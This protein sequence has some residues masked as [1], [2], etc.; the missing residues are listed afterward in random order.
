MRPLTTAFPALRHRNFRLF[1]IGQFISL[2]GTWM[3]TVAQ[4]W[5]VLQL[6][7]S[8]FAV[9]LVSMLGSLPVLLF[10]LY[11]GVLADRVNRRRSVILLQS[12]MLVEALTLALL[13][14]SHRVTVHWVMALALFLGSCAAFEV[15]IRQAFLMEMVGREDLMNAIALNSSVFN[16]TRIIGPAIAGSLIAAA[17]L[18]VCFFANA[19]SYVAVLAGLAVMR[20]P[21][22]R[23]GNGR[24]EGRGLFSE[25]VRYAMGE[26]R[27]RA[28]LLLMATYSVFGFSFI[29]M[30]PVFAREVLGTG[31]AG[32]GGLM[33][34]VGIGAAGGA[35]AIAGFGR[36]LRGDW[37]GHRLIR[38]AGILFGLSLVAVAVAR[39]YLVAALLLG[40]A[41]CAMI[42][43]NVMTNTLLQTEA[44][45]QMRGRIMGFYSWVVLGMAPFGALLAG[46]ISERFGVPVAL[47]FGGGICVIATLVITRPLGRRP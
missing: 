15:P 13:T 40:L 6:T 10:T 17:G 45:D 46:W 39:V 19:L 22:E 9:G 7:N 23:P 8:A 24:V 44:P 5:L 35:L 18:A 27:P 42:L 4:G 25:G 2:C 37:R 28:L 47:A 16:V 14:V 26:S 41:G 21:V 12:L 20:L 33:S 29:A 43:N 36:K 34:A 30:L 1:V 31:A 11:G 38:G 3:Q 32:Y